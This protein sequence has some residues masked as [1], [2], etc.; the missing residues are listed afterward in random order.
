VCALELLGRSASQLPPIE[1]IEE[2][3]A[4]ASATAVAYADIR[5][6]VIY[7][8]ASAPSFRR[9]RAAQASSKE[10]RE[11]DELRLVASTIVHEEWHIRNG[12]DEE[13]AY[14]AQLMALQQMGLGPE[15]AAYHSIRRA[16]RVAL[17]ARA[18]EPR[19]G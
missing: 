7:L 18:R 6:G 13:G 19:S 5:T 17:A 9:A 11:P 16:M 8:I 12:P 3:P 10:C 15:T 14:L 4:G 2:R 1:I